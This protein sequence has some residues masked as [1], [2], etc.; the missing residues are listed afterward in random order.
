MNVKNEIIRLRKKGQS[1]NEI[2]IAL[3]ISKDQVAKVCKRNQ[4]L[5][6]ASTSICKECGVTFDNIKKAGRPQVFCSASCR[7]KWWNKNHELLSTSHKYK[8][9]CS[10]CGKEFMAKGRLNSKYC[11]MEC[12][13]KRGINHE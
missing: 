13:Q 12:Y 11:C 3:N 5:I 10:T 8:H 1:Y 9:K 6:D 7:S 2:A 4:D